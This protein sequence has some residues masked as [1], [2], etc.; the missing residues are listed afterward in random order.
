MIIIKYQLTKAKSRRNVLVRKPTCNGKKEYIESIRP[1]PGGEYK[2]KETI[3]KSARRIL[4]ISQVLKI[5]MVITFALLLLGLIMINYHRGSDGYIPLP[6][7]SPVTAGQ[8]GSKFGIT[9]LTDKGL[10]VRAFNV[11][12]VSI[13]GRM[14]FCFAALL[15]LRGLLKRIIKSY[16]PYEP[17][18]VRH[19]RQLAWLI[20]LSDV[21]PEAAAW[22]LGRLSG[23]TAAFQLNIT[24]VFMGLVFLCVAEIFRYGC[25]LQQEADETL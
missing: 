6:E 16:T 8:A 13:A 22:I 1:I 19:I 10:N 15:I 5:L 11:L 14:A 23:V 3:D 12:L 20:L 17:A 7:H 24:F 9:I 2:M 4:S 18:N 25:Y 21:L